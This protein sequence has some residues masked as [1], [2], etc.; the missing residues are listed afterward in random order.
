MTLY[1]FVFFEFTGDPRDLHVLPHSFPTRLSSDLELDDEVVAGLDRGVGWGHA[2]PRWND[3]PGA[4][5]APAVFMPPPSP[6]CRDTPA[7]HASPAAGTSACP[8]PR[9]GSVRRTGCSA[10]TRPR[11]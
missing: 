9:S 2:R 3:E 1:V 11:P 5:S 6:A 7:P 8:R 10:G 4:V